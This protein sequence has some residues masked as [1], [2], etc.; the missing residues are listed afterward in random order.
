ML[1]CKT[2]VVHALFVFFLNLI[3][4]KEV[5]C[6]ALKYTL[7]KQQ[8][9]GSKVLAYGKVFVKRSVSSSTDSE[10]QKTISVPNRTVK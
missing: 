7:A 8:F 9:F 10:H 1:F 3:H 2:I 4:Y 6:S 5:V